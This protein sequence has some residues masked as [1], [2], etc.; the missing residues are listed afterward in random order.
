MFLRIFGKYSWLS[1][2]LRLSFQRF[3]VET[4]WEQLVVPTFSVEGCV[5]LQSI[6]SLMEVL[7]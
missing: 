4:F 5:L 6:A 2:D 1:C 3:D 7:R